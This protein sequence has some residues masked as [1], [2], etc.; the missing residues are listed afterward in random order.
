MRVG[1]IPAKG[2]GVLQKPNGR[3]LR[4]LKM[5]APPQ[6][7]PPRLGYPEGPEQNEGK[8]NNSTLPSHLA[9]HHVLVAR[10]LPCCRGDTD[11]NCAWPEPLHPVKAVL[12]DSAC[13]QS[14]RNASCPAGR[15]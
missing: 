2:S 11:I 1:Q 14:K 7:R 6:D 3:C 15:G 13:D 4:Y 12:K 9:G 8:C 5:V 10:H